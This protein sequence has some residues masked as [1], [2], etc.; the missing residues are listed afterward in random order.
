MKR[1]PDEQGPELPG[2]QEPEPEL[3]KKPR[4]D[5]PE[6]PSRGPRG[7][8]EAPVPVPQEPSPVPEIPAEGP[9]LPTPDNPSGGD[10]PERPD[11]LRTLACRRLRSARRERAQWDQEAP[12]PRSSAARK[13]RPLGT[14]RP[15]RRGREA[16]VE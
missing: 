2:K 14:A 5:E 4:R 13:P 12:R 7:G 15:L 6:V 10:L 9:S 11:V 3:P 16:S 1:D 8:R